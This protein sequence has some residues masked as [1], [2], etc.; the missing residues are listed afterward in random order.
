MIRRPPRSTQ[1]VSSAASD[2]Y[3]R[4]VSTQS[5]WVLVKFY[6]PW[7]GHCRSLAPIYKEA[8]EKL[9]SVPTVRF[10]EIDSTKNDIPN[11]QIRGYPTIKL[12]K[13]KDKANPIEYNQDR[14]VEKIVEFMKEHSSFSEAK[15][16]LQHLSLI[17]I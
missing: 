16:D 1:G 11:Q 5:T 12:F 8:A 14:T 9:L 6:A 13:A 17:H 3:K 7:C 15:S 10:V 2:V 4:Q